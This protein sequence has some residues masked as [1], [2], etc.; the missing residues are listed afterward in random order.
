MDFFE[1]MKIERKKYFKKIE[2]RGIYDFEGQ[3]LLEVS[4]KGVMLCWYFSDFLGG[5]IGTI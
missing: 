1:N 2:K 4:S 5:K 3:N